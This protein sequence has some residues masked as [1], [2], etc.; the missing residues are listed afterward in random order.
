MRIFGAVQPIET[1]SRLSALSSSETISNIPLF[2]IY[3]YI[4][5]DELYRV[6]T[7]FPAWYFIQKQ[8]FLSL[9][10]IYIVN[11]V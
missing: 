4:Y 5:V 7:I 2:V 10:V 9:S 3:S 6:T 11:S 1:D 8:G